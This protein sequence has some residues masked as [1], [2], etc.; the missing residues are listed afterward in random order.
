MV[1]S[2]S[3][4][5]NLDRT[6]GEGLAARVWLRALLPVGTSVIAISQK[7]ACDKY[8]QY[9]ASLYLPDQLVWSINEQ[10]I[11]AGHARPYDG[12]AR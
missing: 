1:G 3:F 5:A 2:E 8:G 7:E 12:G 10:L 4:L 6:P 9:L 11:E